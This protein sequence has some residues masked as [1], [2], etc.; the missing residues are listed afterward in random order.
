M[1]IVQLGQPGQMVNRMS[2]VQSTTCES[3]T[4]RPLEGV[5]RTAKQTCGRTKIVM[6]AVRDKIV[7]F[8]QESF[9]EADFHLTSANGFASDASDGSVFGHACASNCVSVAA[10]DWVRSIV[11]QVLDECSIL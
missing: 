3:M 10:M 8:R 6:I 11:L 9:I 4:G 5:C 1:A 7:L 2:I